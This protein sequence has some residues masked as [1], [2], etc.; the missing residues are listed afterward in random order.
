MM[1]NFQKW[2]DRHLTAIADSLDAFAWTKATEVGAELDRRAFGGH[3]VVPDDVC[4]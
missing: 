2:L 4:R 1:T 3:R